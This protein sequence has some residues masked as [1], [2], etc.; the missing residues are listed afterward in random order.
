MRMLGFVL[1]SAKRFKAAS[2]YLVLYKALERPY[3]EYASVIWNPEYNNYTKAIE[4]VQ[5]RFLRSMHRR[6]TGKKNTIYPL[7]QLDVK[8]LTQQR[9]LTFVEVI[10]YKSSEV[11]E[12]VRFRVPTR[13]ARSLRS[14]ATFVLCIVFVTRIISCG[15]QTTYLAIVNS[16]FKKRYWIWQWI[17]IN[18]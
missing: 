17:L 18:I 14:L 6:L 12:Q 8:W 2:S 7:L 15:F 11:L 16:N 1:R 13:S 3:L 4:I 5:K 10:N 9:C